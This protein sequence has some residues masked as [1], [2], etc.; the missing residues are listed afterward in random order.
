M[1]I[2][3]SLRNW[4]IGGELGPFRV[5]STKAELIRAVG[6]PDQ[7]G[8]PDNGE[9]TVWQYGDLELLFDAS[10]RP[11]RVSCV[12]MHAFDGVPSGGRKVRI[13]PWIVRSTL[14]L[15]DMR[16]ALT[17]LGVT[18]REEVPVADDTRLDLV[19]RDAPRMSI[20]FVTSEEDGW[21]IG[22]YGLWMSK[23]KIGLY[24]PA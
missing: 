15:A 5:G 7:T 1:K 23:V 24:R 21:P 2:N 3:V 9:D 11:F 20:E 10:E 13:D 6:E 16:Q 18:F 14:P 19:L 8:C 12:E 22:L 17:E 4:I